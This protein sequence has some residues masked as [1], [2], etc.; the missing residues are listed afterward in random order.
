M[1]IIPSVGQIYIKV[2]VPKAGIMDT[3][4]KAS[5]IEVAEVLAVGKDISEY[6]KGD[7]ILF[8]S[9]AVDI[10]DY[11]GKP[12]LFIDITTGGIKAIVK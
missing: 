1:T 12:Y 7:K 6:K 4:S 2:E 8:K 9:W 3:S 11:Q 5:A 10:I